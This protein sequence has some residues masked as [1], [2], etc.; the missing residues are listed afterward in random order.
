M[1]SFVLRA[2]LIASGI[3]AALIAL[4]VVGGAL[5]SGYSQLMYEGW[6]G[7]NAEIFVFDVRRGILRNLT[8][9]PADD[10]HPIWSPDGRYIAFESLREGIRRVY[11][12]DAEGRSVRRITTQMDYG[13]ADPAWSEDGE[14]VIFRL[15]RRRRVN[16]IYRVNIHT[17][18]T[19]QLDLT[20]IPR[21]VDTERIVFMSYREG[22]WGIYVTDPTRTYTYPLLR[23]NIGFSET[24]HWSPDDRQVAFLAQNR[25]TSQVYVMNADGTHFRQAT[26]DRTLKIGLSWRP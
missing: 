4:A 9:H 18:A 22:Q 11:V 6:V 7:D 16:P 3:N 13:E 2:F 12:M 25:A 14:H 15:L 1:M 24:P 20:V 5:T 26:F 10:I 8:N 21:P 23:N 19:E 17:G